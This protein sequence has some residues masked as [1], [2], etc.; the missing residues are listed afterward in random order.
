M[1]AELLAMVMVVVFLFVYW[2]HAVVVH[3]VPHAMRLAL[4]SS[5]SPALLVSAGRAARNSTEAMPGPKAARAG[6]ELESPRPTAVGTERWVPVLLAASVPK[7]YV[8]FLDRVLP[9]RVR[10]QGQLGY[11]MAAVAF[12]TGE[13]GAPARTFVFAVRFLNTIDALLGDPI[14]PG[15]H[16]KLTEEGMRREAW[17]GLVY[18]VN[19]P[20]EIFGKVVTNST[21]FFVASFEDGEIRCEEDAWVATITDQ[22]FLKHQPWERN[23]LADFRLARY[24]QALCAYDG[25][26]TTLFRFR[27]PGPLPAL[28]R[29]AH[30]TDTPGAADHVFN[31]LCEVEDKRRFDKNWALLPVS[32]EMVSASQT[33]MFINKFGETGLEVTS[34]DAQNRCHTLTAIPFGRD[35]I[36]FLGTD[37]LPMFSLGSPFVALPDGSLLAAG[38]TKIHATR[39]L[40]E[41]SHLR[42]FRDSIHQELRQGSVQYIRHRRYIYLLYFVLLDPVPAAEGGQGRSPVRQLGNAGRGFKSADAGPE[43]GV[44]RSGRISD[45]FLP[46]FENPEAAGV[47]H[48]YSLIFPMAV[49]LNLLAEPKT[50]DVFGGY[51][52]AMNVV[53]RFDLGTALASCRHSIAEFDGNEYRCFLLNVPENATGPAAWRG[54][55]PG[56]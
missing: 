41:G 37:S 33:R 52:D 8:P 20:W 47:T 54:A 30:Q 45:S 9:A 36:P 43:P 48:T 23:R 11:N 56:T 40:A 16:P 18:G 6:G 3:I 24:G 13:S 44:P 42:G 21:V 38:H 7:G 10:P 29:S 2:M 15:N 19:S 28:P 49:S 4:E 53:L 1:L 12:S 17:M 22:P 50:L 31:F 51:G 35:S 27:P 46:R 14:V 25:H 26:S 34:H 5:A 39:R 55:A 32:P